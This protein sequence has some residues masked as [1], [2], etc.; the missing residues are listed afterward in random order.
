MA[1]TL[2]KM[3][4]LGMLMP[5]F[6]LPSAQGK[7]WSKTDIAVLPSVLIVMCNH[8]P[9]VQA[10]EDRINQLAR[11]Y[12]GRIHVVGI[13]ANDAEAYPEDNFE[14]MV[15]RSNLKHYAFPYLWD[16]SQDLARALGAVCTPDFFLFNE[17]HILVYRGRLDDSWKDPAQIQHQDL[18]DAV[19]AVLNHRPVS[20]DQKP[21]LGCS[22]KWRTT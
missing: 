2:S 8:C 5:S 9:Y 6:V 15:D 10:V 22:I 12:Q 16:E 20:L 18:R 11:D 4:P 1:L 14:A 19:E 13:N 3:T 21:S 7:V 17:N